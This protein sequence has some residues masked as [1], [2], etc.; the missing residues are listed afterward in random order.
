[1]F[2]W[3]LCILRRL[4]FL[5]PAILQR[6][7]LKQKPIRGELGLSYTSMKKSFQSNLSSGDKISIEEIVL[8]ELIPKITSV[9]GRHRGYNTRRMIGFQVLTLELELKL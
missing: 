2:T 5:I 7:K 1:M 9:L 3:F 4:N 6:Q 8:S